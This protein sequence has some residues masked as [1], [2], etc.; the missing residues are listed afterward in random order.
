MV[1]QLSRSGPEILNI[2]VLHIHI[3]VAIIY[4]Y[5]I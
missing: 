1:S 4:I 3:Y 5:I 2:R